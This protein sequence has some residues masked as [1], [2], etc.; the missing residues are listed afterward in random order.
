MVINRD[1]TWEKVTW[2]EFDL[3]ATYL[4]QQS[5]LITHF[6]EVMTLVNVHVK[7]YSNCSILLHHLCKKELADSRCIL[8][9]TCCFNNNEE[10][11][12]NSD[13]ILSTITQ[14][15]NDLDNVLVNEK[16]IEL[17]K[18]QIEEIKVKSSN[19]LAN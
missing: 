11:K 13:S 3:V 1:S 17:L 10:I 7:C 4:N 16:E 18:V 19:P 6:Y 15:C 8:C 9:S 12:E 14:L 2:P 5:S